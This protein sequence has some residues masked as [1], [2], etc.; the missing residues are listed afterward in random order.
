[1]SEKT[2][3]QKLGVKPGQ[4]VLL[5]QAPKDAASLIGTLPAG[6]ELQTGLKRSNFILVFAKDRAALV[7]GLAACKERLEPKGV[8]WVA[9]I[10]STSAKKVDINRDSIREY[11]PNVGLDTVAQIAI[12]EEWSALRLKAV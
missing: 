5:M 7:K 1:M 4:I 11:V 6:A 2:V 10:K 12:N 8:V 3:A 9:Y